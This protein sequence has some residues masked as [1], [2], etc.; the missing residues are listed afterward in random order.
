VTSVS[1]ATKNPLPRAVGVSISTTAAI[2]LLTTSSSDA[3]MAAADATAA[4]V[5]GTGI[6]RAIGVEGDEGAEASGA[7]RPGAFAATGRC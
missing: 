7:G 6:G 2:A 4:P 5:G 1:G 3:G